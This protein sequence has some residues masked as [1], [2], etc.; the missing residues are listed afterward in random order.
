MMM[1]MFKRWAICFK[2]DNSPVDKCLYTHKS[3]AEKVIDTMKNKTK[4]IINHVE[5]KI[6]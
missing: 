3:E 2:H 1:I 5:I 4:L 6:L